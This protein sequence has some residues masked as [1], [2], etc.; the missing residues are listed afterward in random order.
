MR[1]SVRK[2][3]EQNLQTKSANLAGHPAVRAGRPF[4]KLSAGL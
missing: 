4:V 2:I 3:R 1:D